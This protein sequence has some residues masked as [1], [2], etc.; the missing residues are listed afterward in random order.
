MI[1][2]KQLEALYWVRQLGNYQKAA[3]RISV[4][5][6]AI[7]ARLATMEEMLGARLIDRTPGGLG[8]TRLGLEVADHAEQMLLLRDGMLE[9]VRRDS[10]TQVRVAMV[11]PASTC[12]GERLLVAARDEPDISL[13]FTVGSNVQISRDIQSGTVDLAFLSA[14]PHEETST[15]D[16]GMDFEIGWVGAPNFAPADGK[17][18]TVS[19]LRKS[20]LVLYPPTSP[21]YSPVQSI[22][23]TSS[24]Q[25]GGRHFANSLPTIC[26]MLRQGYGMSAI[27]LAVVQDDISSGRL[28]HVPAEEKITPLTIYCSHVSR[29]RE[30]LVRRVLK[31]AQ[32]AAADFCAANSETTRFYRT[33][34]PG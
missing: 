6:P 31:L 25:S 29:Q 5:Q 8:F 12:W 9:T 13:E 24:T 7:S 10:K 32:N 2:F 23:T 11:G 27:P 18:L 1:N 26:D 3:D 15:R 30:A 33:T 16:F 4:T 20:D 22:L 28:V 14:L 19:Q 17:P 21:L 34:P